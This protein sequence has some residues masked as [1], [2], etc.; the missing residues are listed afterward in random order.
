MGLRVACG[1]VSTGILMVGCLC[2][3]QQIT[4][5]LGPTHEGG[6]DVAGQNDAD[7]REREAGGG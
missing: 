6:D 2:L 4:T 7:A 5:I 3:H 1:T